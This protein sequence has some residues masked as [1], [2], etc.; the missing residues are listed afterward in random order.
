MT[1]LDARILNLRSACTSCVAI[2]EHLC[3]P[4]HQVWACLKRHGRTHEFRA[5]QRPSGHSKRRP[6]EVAIYATETAQLIHDLGPL[7]IEEAVGGGFIASFGD[8]PG[9]AK[10]TIW[11]AIR[12][13]AEA[14]EMEREEG[15]A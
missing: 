13:A 4:E 9:Q 11:E 3:I 6:I 12:D 5:K 8:E 10:E 15:T 2:A 14:A 1:D 7:N